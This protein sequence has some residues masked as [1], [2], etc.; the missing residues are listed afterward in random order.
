MVLVRFKNKEEHKEIK[1]KLKEM[2]EFIEDLCYMI[3]ERAEE[4]YEEEYRG[5][6]YRDDYDEMRGG[7]YEYRRGGGRSR[8]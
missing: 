1:M 6:R 8:M 2:K 3:E 7:R 4:D 5:G